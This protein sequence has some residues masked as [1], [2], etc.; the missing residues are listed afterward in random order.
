MQRQNCAIQAQQNAPS[1]S[2]LPLLRL[3]EATDHVVWPTS[4]EPAPVDEWLVLTEEARRGTSEQRH[5]VRLVLATTEFAFL[6][7]P[8]RSGKTTANMRAHPAA[9]APG[10]AR[11]PLRLDARRR[12]QRA[13][14]THGRERTGSEP[15]WFFRG[16]CRVWQDLVAVEM[17]ELR[18]LIAPMV[19]ALVKS[20][21]RIIDLSVREGVRVN[22]LSSRR[23]A[24]SPIAHFLSRVT[25]RGF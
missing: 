24:I 12:R 15:C 9:G 23:G 2:H 8:P 22:I 5:F 21:A 16:F 3:M 13:R 25:R 20:G 14:A 11:A 1:S 4:V 6:E 19:R 10:E 7:G 17:S 18:W